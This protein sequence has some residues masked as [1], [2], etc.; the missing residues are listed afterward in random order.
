MG[1]YSFLTNDLYDEYAERDISSW[2]RL[3]K[4]GITPSTLHRDGARCWVRFTWSKGYY[5]Q[6]VTA[7]K[8]FLRAQFDAQD[9][10]VPDDG[11][12]ALKRAFTVD[13]TEGI[14]S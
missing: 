9:T 10:Y 13:F 6:A 2:V 12:N 14:Y 8:A 4:A 1:L 11:S 7:A 3:T 5:A